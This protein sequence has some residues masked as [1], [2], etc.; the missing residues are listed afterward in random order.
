MRFFHAGDHARHGDRAGA[1]KVAVILHPSPREEI[2]RGAV[3]GQW[4]VLG[5]KAVRCAHPVIDHFITVFTGAVE[6]HRAAAADAAHPGLQHTQGKRRGDHRVHAI[7]ARRQHIGADTSG[8]SADCAATMPP[9]EETAGL[10]IC[11]A[12][13]N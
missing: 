2:G 8:L 3:A 7:A 5:A 13:E 12:L 11:W 1:M 10:R 6:H 9:L 4:I